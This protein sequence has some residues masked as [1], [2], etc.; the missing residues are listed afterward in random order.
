MYSFQDSFTHGHIKNKENNQERLNIPIRRITS[1]ESSKVLTQ[2]EARAR[3]AEYKGVPNTGSS[4]SICAP[5]DSSSS[6]HSLW[7]FLADSWRGDASWYERWTEAAH[8]R[9]N[10][11]QAAFPLLQALK[12]GVAPSDLRL[13]PVEI[14]HRPDVHPGMPRGEETLRPLWVYPH[15]TPERWGPWG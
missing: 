8:S 9:T 7:P 13:C 4:K 2:P 3:Q 12:S 10:P 6:R 1:P 5:W 15:G 14:W 11:T